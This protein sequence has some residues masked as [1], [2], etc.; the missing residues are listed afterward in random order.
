MTDACLHP[1]LRQAQG[2][3]VPSFGIQGV[4]LFFGDGGVLVVGGAAF[5]YEVLGPELA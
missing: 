2:P 5:F 1:A 3:G 4:E